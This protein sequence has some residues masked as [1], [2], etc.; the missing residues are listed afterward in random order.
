MMR[1]PQWRWLWESL[2]AE[3]K[4]RGLNYEMAATDDPVVEDVP[5]PVEVHRKIRIVQDLDSTT[6]V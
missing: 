6:T 2:I 1:D 3:L 4:F 5:L